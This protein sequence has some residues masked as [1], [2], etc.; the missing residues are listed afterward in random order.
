[1]TDRPTRIDDRDVDDRDLDDASV[2]LFGLGSTTVTAALWVFAVVYV[3]VSIGAGWEITSVA[4]WV[5]RAIGLGIFAVAVAIV[6]RTRGSRSPVPAAVIVVVSAVCGLAVSL[7]SLPPETYQ[8]LQ[9]APPVSAMTIVLTLLAVHRRPLYAW[10]GAFCCT[11]VSG[12]WAAD[13]G[14]GFATGAV[15]TNFCYPVLVLAVLF[16][17]MA[18][19]M[20]ERIRVLR[21][22]A[23]AQAATEAATAAAARERGRQLRRLDR[24]ARPILQQVVDGH[25]FT[26]AEVADARLTEAQLR[27]GIRAPAW[28]S[29]QVSDAVWAARRRGISVLLLDDGALA[30]RPDDD[31]TARLHEVLVA[32]LRGAPTGQVT[33]RVLPPDRDLLASIVVNAGP[34]IRRIECATDGVVTVQ[35]GSVSAVVDRP[36]VG[37]G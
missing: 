20:E 32:E 33:A 31:L 16:A 22:R 29:G 27:D 12:L 30:A 36:R 21:V 11:A 2:D 4:S 1:M 10:V 8:T 6:V 7:W 18:R 14:L 5:G 26:P 13:V 35:D 34:D 19:P 9:T 17:L 3:I 23:V 15:N 28:E 37:G 24:R 25:E